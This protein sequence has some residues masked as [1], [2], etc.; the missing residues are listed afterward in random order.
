LHKFMEFLDR[1]N[2]SAP[3]FISMIDPES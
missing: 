3:L 2:G 1:C